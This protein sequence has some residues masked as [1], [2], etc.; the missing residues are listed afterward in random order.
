V[1]RR[2]ARSILLLAALAL[3]AAA[4]IVVL[5]HS[6][7][8]QSLPAEQHALP[9]ADFPMK[10]LNGEPLRLSEYQGKVILLD[11]WAS[12]CA[13]CREEIPH[14]VEWQAKYGGSGLQVIGI[15]MDDDAGAAEKSSRELRMN[16]P[17]VAGSAKLAD[18]FGGVFG[19]PA[20]IVIGREG[21][22]VARRLGVTDL[23]SLERE[24][25]AQLALKP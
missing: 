17:V 7:R 8:H 23:S 12:W 4:L 1:S 25:T 13:P 6:H 20:N 24:L 15:A 16:Y 2:A 18:Q 10:Q 3:A 22:V 14:L 5:R 21:E 11:F 9:A 19:L